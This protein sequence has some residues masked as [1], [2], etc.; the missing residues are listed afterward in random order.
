ME[1]AERCDRL[2]ILH[3][4]RIVAMGT[5]DALK[6]EIGGDVISLESDDPGGLAAK[7]NDKLEAQAAVVDG[8]VRAP[9][10]SNKGR[11]TQLRV[12]ESTVL[13]LVR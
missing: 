13:D 10:G 12:N 1:E 6:S 2:A 7:I 9:E 3:E 8:T 11:L 4:G 5:P